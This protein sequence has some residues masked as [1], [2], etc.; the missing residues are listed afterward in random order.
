MSNSN[1]MFNHEAHYNCS[2]N[3]SKPQEQNDQCC[4]K[5]HKNGIFK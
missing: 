3:H 1:E 5:N 2:H 4:G